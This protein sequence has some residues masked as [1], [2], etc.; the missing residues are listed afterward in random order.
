MKSFTQQ[1][2]LRTKGCT[3][4]EQ[5]RSISE[6]LARV[7]KELQFVL[8]IHLVKVPIGQKLELPDDFL[9]II[10]NQVLCPSAQSESDDD[11][12]IAF[13]ITMQSQLEMTAYPSRER[14]NSLSSLS[15][16]RL[17]NSPARNRYTMVVTS[18]FSRASRKCFSRIAISL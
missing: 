5:E 15:P 12:N 8:I 1:Y 9:R 2:C 11:S 14:E 6:S 17:R 3:A 10:F 16:P 4:V 13:N 7:A 18:L